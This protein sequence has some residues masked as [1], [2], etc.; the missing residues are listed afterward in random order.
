ME[1]GLAALNKTP[2]PFNQLSWYLSMCPLA[3]FRNPARAVA[4][5]RQAVELQPEVAGYWNTLALAEYRSHDWKAALAALEQSM[6]L[7]HG[8]EREDW[9]ILAMTHWQLG[10]KP[11]ARDWY[12]KSRVWLEKKARRLRGY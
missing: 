2:Q 8:G 10:D 1:R 6:K 12:D 11:K 9:L 7:A 3:Q 5:A 4:L